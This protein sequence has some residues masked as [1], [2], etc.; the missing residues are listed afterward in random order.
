MWEKPRALRT[1]LL[2]CGGTMMLMDGQFSHTGFEV[3]CRLL[4]AL[5]A[6]DDEAD[7]EDMG[8]TE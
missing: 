7:G 1:L 5:F 6:V 4:S 8:Q 3:R 2:P